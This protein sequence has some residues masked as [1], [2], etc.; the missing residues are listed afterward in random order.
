M[1]SSDYNMRRV[2]K[3]YKK[4][5][6]GEDSFFFVPCALNSELLAGKIAVYSVKR[7]TVYGATG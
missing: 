1:I 4:L 2:W 5:I 7:M 3:R 6:D